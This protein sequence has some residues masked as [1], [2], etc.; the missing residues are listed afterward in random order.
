MRTKLTILRWAIEYILGLFTALLSRV[1]PAQAGA[2][3]AA[4]AAPAKPGFLACSA[5]A[6]LIRMSRPTYGFE[7]TA[8]AAG[9][10][11]VCGVDE[12]GRGP[13][14]G[15]V[16]AAAVILDQ[17]K[18]P[19]GLNDSKKLSPAAR[20]KLFPEIIAMAE[21]GIGFATVAEIDDLNIL[22]ATYLAMSRAVAALNSKPTLALIDGNRAPPLSCATQTIIAG[23][24]KSLSIAAA[25]IIAKVTRDRVMIALHDT[26]SV[27]GFHQ[28]KGYGTEAHAAALAQH[29][30]CTE[31]RR[32]FAPIRA[33]LR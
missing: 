23:D 10:M 17:R 29:G 15:P 31:H 27:Y 2:P 1:T 6:I 20:E 3:L 19:K 8:R 11:R 30:P 5:R 25:S 7:R 32:S 26:F 18:V 28:H 4:V 33:L 13:W 16:C 22:Q 12:A 9:H 24:S 21:V 14:A